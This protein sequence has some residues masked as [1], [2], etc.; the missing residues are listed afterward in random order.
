[1]T[2][3]LACKMWV[4]ISQCVFPL[5]CLYYAGFCDFLAVAL[6]EWKFMGCWGGHE[7]LPCPFPTLFSPLVA[8]SSLYALV[9]VGY[10][11]TSAGSDMATALLLLHEGNDSRLVREQGPARGKRLL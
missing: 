3:L 2:V 9:R 8:M 5:L 6:P 10:P 11:W 1:M 4:C 7:S